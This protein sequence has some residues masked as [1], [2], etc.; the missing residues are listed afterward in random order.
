MLR[1]TWMFLARTGTPRPVPTAI[2]V[3]TLACLAGLAACTTGP[4]AMFG[5]TSQPPPFDQGS[6]GADQAGSRST[7]V[8]LLLPLTGANAPLGQAMLKSA[9]LALD[10]PGAPALDPQDT[11]DAPGGAA[12]AA[13]AALG[14]GDGI[15]LGPLTS[16]DTAQAAPIAHAA[17]VPMLAFT[18]DLAQAQPGIWVMGVTPEQQVRRLVAAAKADNRN[19]IAALLPD[20]ALGHSMTDA[21]RQA[22]S[23]AGLPAPVVAQHGESMESVNAAMRSL[24]DFADRRGAIE[25]KV[26]DAKASQDPAVRAT[27]AA[28]GQTPIPP[29][30]FDALLLADTGIGLQEVISV[31]AYYDVSPSQ[32]RIMGPLLWGAFAGKLHALEGAWFAGPDPRDRRG[33]ASLYEKKFGQPPR[34]LADIPY[35]AA[36]LAGSL[37]QRGGYGVDTLTR[38][39]GFAGVDGIFA[40][41]PD[42]HVR[43]GL[44]IFQIQPGGG[45]SIIQPAP[46]SLGDTNT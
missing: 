18:S 5:G 19:R 22:C 42:G 9:Q 21:L 46:V 1:R 44:A 33:F 11:G 7:R 39:D 27:A 26:K 30:P 17:G 15:L 13:Q 14:G 20:N 2:R 10:A 31:L 45:A 35:D 4:M 29:P 38:G 16:A 40:L 41:Q 36:A 28:L 34:P 12:R 3:A 24:S 43:R 32:V 23:D 25:Q 37:S 6:P 8:G